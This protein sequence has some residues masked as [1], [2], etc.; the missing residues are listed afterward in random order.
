[1]VEFFVRFNA[2]E[3]LE[4]VTAHAVELARKTP[5]YSTDGLSHMVRCGLTPGTCEAILELL[6]LLRDWDGLEYW[7]DGDALEE[8]R[9]GGVP[10]PRG[11]GPG[12]IRP[13]R[14]GDPSDPLPHPPSFLTL[15]PLRARDG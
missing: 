4:P 9:G 6:E 5:G 11:D 13:P 2:A 1:M 12:R 10:D 3:A 8:P 7:L 14:V 15:R